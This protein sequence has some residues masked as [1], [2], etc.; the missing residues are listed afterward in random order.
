MTK[1]RIGKLAA[2]MAAAA[3]LGLAGLAQAKPLKVGIVAFQMSSE[4][5]ARTAQAAEAAAK[6]KGW[7]VTQLNPGAPCPSTRPRSRTSSRPR[8]TPSSFA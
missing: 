7:E 5:H 1:G 3:L 6:A 4:T 2:L 8:W